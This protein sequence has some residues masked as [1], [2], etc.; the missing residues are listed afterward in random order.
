MASLS[1]QNS[2]MDKASKEE[3]TVGGD[4]AKENG[5]EGPELRVYCICK[6][7]DESRAMI[8]C[9]SCK[10]WFHF[11]CVGIDQA[12]IPENYLCPACAT[13]QAKSCK[14]EKN[15]KKN[16]KKRAAKI[17]PIQAVSQRE[18]GVKK[19]RNANPLDLLL[20]A[21]EEVDRLQKKR[22]GSSGEVRHYFPTTCFYSR[23]NY[24][25]G[26]RVNLALAMVLCFLSVLPLLSL[27][28]S[29]WLSK[30][31]LRAKQLRPYLKRQS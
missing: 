28:R 29:L 19:M 8:E 26:T 25:R 11:D 21:A 6:S 1:A 30:F 31:F 12:L 7:A 10:D 4:G 17:P 15:K 20:C 14:N 2:Q 27:G 18:E 16:S 22:E 24:L 9:D 13:E 3:N 23:K 5:V